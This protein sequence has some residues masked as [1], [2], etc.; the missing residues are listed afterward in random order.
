MCDIL[1]DWEKLVTQRLEHEHPDTFYD[2]MTP[3]PESMIKGKARVT[4]RF[5]AYPGNWAGRVFYVRVM[6]SE[7]E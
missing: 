1:V 5:E 7:Q 4:I 6:R 3:L 2:E